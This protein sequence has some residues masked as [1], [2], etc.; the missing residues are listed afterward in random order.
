M[1][2]RGSAKNDL[3]PEITIGSG[4]KP[5][6]VQFDIVCTYLTCGHALE[7]RIDK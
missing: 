4:F 2:N 6:A 7:K 5:C 3:I 1:L